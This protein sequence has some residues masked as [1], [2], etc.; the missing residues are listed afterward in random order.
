VLVLLAIPFCLA[1]IL[2]TGDEGLAWFTD[3]VAHVNVADN[4]VAG[5][6]FVLSVPLPPLDSFADGAAEYPYVHW[7][8]VY[9]GLLAALSL[10]AGEPGEVARWVNVA[11]LAA[12]IVLIGAVTS[13]LTEGNRWASLV[14][15][16]VFALSPAGLELHA[17]LG[18]EPLFIALGLSSLLALAAYLDSRR[19]VLLVLAGLASA[20]LLL[21]KYAG[22]PLLAVECLALLLW[23]AGEL[24]ERLR[25]ALVFGA[26]CAAPYLA[27]LVYNLDRAG[28]ASGREPRWHPP[29]GDNIEVGAAD[30]S[31]WFAPEFLPAGVRYALI[32]LMI[33]AILSVYRRG[34]AG[35]DE[36][37]ARMLV[38]FAVLFSAAAVVAQFAFDALTPLESRLFGPALVVLIP[39]LARLLW[40]ETRDRAVTS[41]AVALGVAG[42]LVVS[43][44][45]DVASGPGHLSDIERH[46][47]DSEWLSSPTIDRLA[48]LPSGIR[49]YSNAPEAVVQLGHRPAKSVPVRTD[50]VIARPN[51]RYAEQVAELRRDVSRHLAVVVY[52][53]AL[54]FRDF[55][56]TPEELMRLAPGLRRAEDSGDG[57]IYRS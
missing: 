32:A 36:R 33:V 24:R 28:T 34:V 45:H 21:V 42:V 46:Y 56:A 12:N 17:T 40:L 3:S 41:R 6:G 48:D 43:Y 1:L 53:D 31:K 49:I 29:T 20:T 27:W 8:P 50:P 54:D 39:L 51:P 22:P 23:S 57:V 25:R 52:F 44:V 37:L 13:R 5:H 55:L 10:I 19:T 11:V 15:A 26:A 16:A 14:A 18:Y 7:P 35:G 9:P 4:V 47:R 30:V 2:A 38:W